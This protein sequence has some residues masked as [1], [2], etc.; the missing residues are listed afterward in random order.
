MSWPTA[1]GVG[2]LQ[3]GAPGLLRPAEHGVPPP[4]A[5][6]AVQA[7]SSS[8]A[9][10]YFFLDILL[11]SVFCFLLTITEILLNII[12]NFFIVK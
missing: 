6:A 1:C 12:F 3:P 5:H 10:P 8:Q 11:H 9:K 2:A 7:P 4:R